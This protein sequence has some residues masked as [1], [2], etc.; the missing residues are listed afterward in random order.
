MPFENIVGKGENCGHQQFFPFP[1]S[2][3]YHSH[4]KF[5]FQNYIFLSSA[6]IFSLGKSYSLSFGKEL[7]PHLREILNLR[8]WSICVLCLPI[9]LFSQR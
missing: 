7:K 8:N 5:Q 2:V 4:T 6:N 9:G 3:N 1:H